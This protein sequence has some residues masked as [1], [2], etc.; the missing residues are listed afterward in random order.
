LTACF[1]VTF[2]HNPEDPR[3]AIGNLGCH[4]VPDLDLLFRLFAAVPMAAI[5]HNSRRYAGLGHT[6]GRC[7]DVFRVVIGI[8]TAAQN[9]AAIFV[10]G[11]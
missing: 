11:G 3:V 10:A 7:I 6:L 1:Q 9:D 8:A 4:L 2:D 5:D